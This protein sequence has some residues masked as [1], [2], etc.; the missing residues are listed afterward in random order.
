MARRFDSRR[1]W[2]RAAVF[3]AIVQVAAI[4]FLLTLPAASLEVPRTAATAE[5]DTQLDRVTRPLQAL[6]RVQSE[7]AAQGWTLDRYERANQFSRLLNDDASAYHYGVLALNAQTQEITLLRD[8]AQAAITRQDYLTARLALNRL[9]TAY[10]DDANAQ[11][12]AGLLS[13]ALGEVDPARA[14]LESLSVQPAYQG[15]ALNVLNALGET[16]GTLANVL[17]E[18]DQPQFAEIAFR[19]A[20]QIETTP[21]LFAGLALAQDQQGK[22]GDSAMR[23]ALENGANDPLIRVLEGLHHRAHANDAASLAALQAAY[24]L[25]PDDPAIMAELA[26]AHQRMGDL[27]AARQLLVQALALSAND[28]RYAALLEQVAQTEQA[29]LDSIA[30]RTPTAES[31]AP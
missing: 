6:Y 24:T 4:V 31:A 8:L 7:A 16:D 25:S 28:P 30:P 11:L 22:N 1:Q 2:K 15:L 9:L 17:L 20:L 23:A 21:R 14:L 3:A 18:A 13:A 29:A 5:T 10:P 26:I 12:Q 19:T 27:S